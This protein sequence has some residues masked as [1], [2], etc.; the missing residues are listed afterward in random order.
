[1]KLV[2]LVTP[3]AI[4][5]LLLVISCAGPAETP[6]VPTP[7][8]TLPAPGKT[9]IVAS[10]ADAGPNTLRQALMDAR[11]GDTIT[12]DPAVF[13]PSKPATI[14]LKAEDHDS[15]LPNVNQGDLTIDASDA[16]VILNGSNI[17]GEWISGLKI[18]SDSN[19]IWGLQIVNFS[20]VGIFLGNGAR[21]NTIGGDRSVGLG[22]LG[23]G[24]LVS[25]N[26]GGI[27]LYGNG[28]SHN[29]IT[30]N[31]VGTDSTGVVNQ[32][33]HGTGIYVSD[34]ASYNMLG[35]DN[36]IAYNYEEGIQINNPNSVGNTITRNSIHDNGIGIFLNG[37]GNTGMPAPFIL[38][39]DLANGTVIGFAGAD[40][41][42]E[43]FSDSS[44]EGEVYEGQ[45]TADS[46]G[47]F[48]LSKGASLVGPHLTIIATDAD[49]NT[50]E[51]S[52]P[53]SGTYRATSLQEGN[54]LPRP[55]LQPKQS[56]ELEDNRIGIHFNDLWKLEPEVFPEGVLDASHIL[57]QGMKRARFAIN[58]FDSD[59]V[60]W[61]NPE[62]T[63]DPSHDD[64]ITSLADNGIT[65]TYVLS[66]WDKE[67][68][69][70]G[71]EV[72]YPRFKTEDDI[73]RYLDFVQFIVHHFKDRIQ[74]YEIW[75]EPD[76]RDTIQWIEVED[77][78][79]LVKRTIPVIRQ[80]YP[81]AKIV[82][83]GLSYLIQSDIQ[84]YLFTILRSDDIMPLVDV[85]SFHSMYGTSPEY[86]LHKQYYYNYPSL[87][88]EIKDTASAHGFT[89]EYVA[90]ELS[91]MTPECIAYPYTYYSETVAAKYYARGIMMNLGI[92]VIV[93]QFYAV[94]EEHPIQI[95]STIRNLATVMAGNKPIDLPIEIQS[96]ATNIKSYSF[97]LSNGDK[98][99]ALWTD[100]IAMDADPGIE[101]KLTISGFPAK[102]V[103][104]I[105]V[106]NGFEQQMIMS[107]EDGN[108]VIRNLLVRDYPIILRFSP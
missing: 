55:Q 36:I 41:T 13:P 101:A 54:N 8:P 11:R 15:S 33:N 70:Q 75:N 103:V 50:S 49:G 56:N 3:A 73:Q 100:G 31:L 51:F 1:M 18:I 32:G 17:P 78:I 86:D 74:Y 107:I 98:L 102:E 44:N 99:L 23:Q 77:Y 97:S 57:K 29:T 28:T 20:G 108:L 7:T 16:G 68:V 62:N 67:Y 90:D 71:G 83:G 92:D 76:I 40:C 94:P 4:A 34:G 38:E 59:R 35:P 39:F 61:S 24:N 79:K 93:S 106:L 60:H 84:E 96:E 43:I 81:E 104:G 66:F 45:T 105:D 85:I 72:L 30:G 6:G 25:S 63:I 5:I 22:L 2:K 69:A 91:W 48:T 27:Q 53:T 19:T 37:G 89:G 14:F 88:Q 47:F 12:F 95:V 52:S 9:I 87:I 80:E 58:N 42:V 64:F 82:V 46:S 26:R 21:N 65:L 10:T